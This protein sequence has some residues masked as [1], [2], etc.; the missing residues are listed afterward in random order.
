MDIQSVSE[1]LHELADKLVEGQVIVRRGNQEIEISVP[2]T[3]VFELKVEEEL[4]K[5]KTQQSF[6]VEISWIEG[7]NSQGPVVLG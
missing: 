1:F 7:D 5:G 3:V 2:K 6:E 4:K